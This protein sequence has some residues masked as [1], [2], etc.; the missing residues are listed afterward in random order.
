MKNE[1]KTKS[2]FC[3]FSSKFFKNCKFCAI[4]EFLP[5]SSAYPLLISPPILKNRRRRVLSPC[6]KIAKNTKKSRKS[7][8]RSSAQ[9]VNLG[10]WRTFRL[11]FWCKMRNVTQ[12]FR[13]SDEFWPEIFGVDSM[14]LAKFARFRPFYGVSVH[15][16]KFLT[17][18]IH[19]A[20]FVEWQKLRGVSVRFKNF[21]THPIHLALFVAWQKLRGVSVHFE[22]FRLHFQPH[23]PWL[24]TASEHKKN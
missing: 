19:L 4:C 7:Q 16:E 2:K 24:Q 21:S 12:F 5:K 15:I 22:K 18:R 11:L 23:C 9:K 10:K 13:D 20:P 14:N 6:E 1:S 8:S 3:K 17:Q